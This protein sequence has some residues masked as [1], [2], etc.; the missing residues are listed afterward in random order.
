M[1]AEIISIGDELLIGQVINTNQAYIA[2]RLNETGVTVAA[3][4]TV[5]DDMDA[6]L[7]AFRTALSRCDVVTVTGGLGPTHDDI[8]RSA[9]CSFFGTDLVEDA[10]ALKNVE[11]LF[12]GWNLPV[13]KVNREQALVPRGCTV[14]P[15]SNGTAP[16]YFFE[17]DGKVFIVMPGVP[18]EMK[19]M[20]DQTVVPYFIAKEPGQAVVHRT[21]RTTGIGESMLA[22]HLGEITEIIPPA[23]QVTLAFL[24]SPTGVRLRLSAVAKD[25]ATAESRIAAVEARIRAKAEKFIYGVDDDELEAVVGEMLRKAKLKLAVAESCTGGLILD[26]LTDVPGSSDYLERGFIVYSNESKLQEL[27]VPQDLLAKHGAVSE[28]V[29]RAMAYGARRATGTDIALSTTGIAGPAG[30]TPGKPVGLVFVGYADKAGSLALKFNFGL[31]RRRTK[32]RAA[33]AALELLRRKL[34]KL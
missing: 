2:R 26:R 22:E 17:R 15:N 11:R 20:M 19:G 29:A 14:I 27:G 13:T 7:A 16:G 6:I 28:E 34:L 24:P 23:E 1:T 18:F 8:T 30:A 12:Q 3:M 4:T 10:D 31:D 5:G 33:Q 9:V 25:R 21:L 32:E